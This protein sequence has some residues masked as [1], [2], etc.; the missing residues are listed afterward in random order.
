MRRLASRDLRLTVFITTVFLIIMGFLVGPAITA[1]LPPRDPVSPYDT[2]ELV[3]SQIPA[4]GQLTMGGNPGD[5]KT[6]VLDTSHGNRVTK[7]ELMPVINAITRAGHRVEVVETKADFAF[8]V[9]KADALIIADPA[10][11][12]APSE[13]DAVEAFVDQGGRLLLLGEPNQA[14]LE[15]TQLRSAQSHIASVAIRFGIDFGREALFDLA[16]NDGNHR[17]IVGVGTDTELSAGVD[18]VA[19]FTATHVSARDGHAVVLAPATTAGD[20][21]GDAPRALAVRT[22][23][24][25]AIGD[26]TF[27]RNENSR[28]ANNGAF[29]SNLLAFLSGGDRGRPITAYPFMVREEATVRYTSPLFVSPAQR[30]KHTLGTHGIPVTIE[31][32]RRAVLPADT[33]VLITSYSYLDQHPRVADSAGIDV[34]GDEVSV[35]GYSGSSLAVVIV[36]MPDSGFDL[37]IVSDTP[38][39]TASAIG[40]IAVG[41]HPNSTVSNSTMIIQGNPERRFV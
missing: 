17:N 33:D 18:Q 15:G 39:R 7:T 13:A 8:A 22:G 9:R 36:H 19:F 10:E 41:K 4:T 6:V 24:V 26:T 29:V 5:G 21:S 20:R 11:P 32:E 2:M 14:F 40:D 16:V 31:L 28:V 3:P 34:S 35:P 27:L 25:T 38:E 12:Y 30:F 1:V 37:V 23:N